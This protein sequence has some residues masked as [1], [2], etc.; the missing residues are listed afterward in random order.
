MS[1][2]QRREYKTRSD[3]LLNPGGHDVQSL[4]LQFTTL[5]DLASVLAVNRELHNPDVIRQALEVHEVFVLEG[6]TEDR[7]FAKKAFENTRL[8]RALVETKQPNLHRLEFVN[9]HKWPD[10]QK[11]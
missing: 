10:F 11:G 9:L 1:K 8:A 4:I 7:L 6:K 2:R 3:L 5:S